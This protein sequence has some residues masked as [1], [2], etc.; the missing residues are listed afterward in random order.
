MLRCELYPAWGAHSRP[1]RHPGTRAREQR[2]MVKTVVSGLA[3][4]PPESGTASVQ[5]SYPP[6]YQRLTKDLN[7]TA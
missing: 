5:R 1:V 4:R 3:V 6:A 7:H 2:P